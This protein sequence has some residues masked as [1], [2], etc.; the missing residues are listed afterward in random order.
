MPER[1]LHPRRTVSHP[2][3]RSLLVAQRFPVI[4]LREIS[5]EDPG[6][7]QNSAICQFLDPRVRKIS[8]HFPWSSGNYLER[9]VRPRL[10]PPPS[11]WRLRRLRRR[12]L[13]WPPPKPRGSAGFRVRAPVKPNRR[14]W[15]PGLEDAAAGDCLRCRVGRFGS[16]LGSHLRRASVLNI[17]PR[18]D[19]GGRAEK[20]NRIEPDKY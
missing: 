20:P 5:A 3:R 1:S 15:L 7:S 4:G 8:L 12:S 14:S 6:W 9:R 10:L 2:A 11:S 17:H 16:A 18:M 13:S 19:I